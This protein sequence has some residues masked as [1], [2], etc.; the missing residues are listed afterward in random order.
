MAQILRRIFFDMMTRVSGWKG[1]LVFRG[2]ISTDGDAIFHM[3]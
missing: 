2:V 1:S 3:V